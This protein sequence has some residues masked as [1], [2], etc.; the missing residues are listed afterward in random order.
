M[1]Y[2]LQFYQDTYKGPIDKKPYYHQII[3]WTNQGD[4]E[5]WKLYAVEVD[6]VEML[7]C[8]FCVETTTRKILKLHA[9]DHMTKSDFN[10]K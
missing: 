7:L 3:N 5:T 10:R 4:K 1:Q 8:S 6:D 9:T 2:R